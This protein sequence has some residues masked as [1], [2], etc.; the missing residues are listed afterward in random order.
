MSHYQEIIAVQPPFDIGPDNNRRPCF[1]CNYDCQVIDFSG[2]LEKEIS[3]FLAFM[4]FGVA[5][6][7]IWYGRT[8]PIPSEGGPYI[9]I[10]NTGGLESDISNDNVSLHNL[11]FQII[12]R[13]AKYDDALSRAYDIWRLLDGRREFDI[14][15]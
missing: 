3:S 11:S 5:M 15:L 14:N 9:H 4:G 7:T 10:F 6:S 1:S 8:A 2:K 13:A 12:V